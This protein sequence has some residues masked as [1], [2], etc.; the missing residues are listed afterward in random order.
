MIWCLKNFDI[1]ILPHL[2]PFYGLLNLTGI[3][4]AYIPPGS[5]LD[6]RKEDYVL[7][8]IIILPY[9]SD[10]IFLNS[11][12]SPFRAIAASLLTVMAIIVLKGK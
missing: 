1:L 11:F 3:L 9:L 7:I 8:F 12:L 5:F 6:K 4:L 10:L 2:L